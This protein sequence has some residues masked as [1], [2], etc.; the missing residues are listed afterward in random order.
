MMSVTRHRSVPKRCCTRHPLTTARDHG[1]GNRKRRTS[2]IFAHVQRHGR[3]EGVA[4][5]IHLLGSLVLVFFGGLNSIYYWPVL[6][7]SG[8][9]ECGSRSARTRWRTAVS[10]I[11]ASAASCEKPSI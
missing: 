6:F 5:V 9:A 8:F 2:F 4:F 3:A 10:R 7:V 1:C 11:S